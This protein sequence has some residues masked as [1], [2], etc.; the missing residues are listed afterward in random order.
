[1]HAT[2]PRVLTALLLALAALPTDA[3]AQRVP[4]LLAILSVEIVLVGEP[5]PGPASTGIVLSTSDG[6]TT[7]KLDSAAMF[8][9][10]LASDGR[11][12]PCPGVT[13]DG[14][15]GEILV[16]GRVPDPRSFTPEFTVSADGAPA[17]T[18]PTFSGDCRAGGGIDLLPGSENTCRVTFARYETGKDGP[19]AVVVV[20]KHWDPTRPPGTLPDGT[21][22]LYAESDGSESGRIALSDLHTDPL[23]VA[24]V[25]ADARFGP[26]PSLVETIDAAGWLGI[27]GGQCEGD[28][29]D[30]VVIAGRAL[31]CE[32]ANVALE[33]TV[34]NPNRVLRIEAATL[35]TQPGSPETASF[36][37]TMTDGQSVDLHAKQMFGPNL[38]ADGRQ[39]PCSGLTSV[40]CVGDVGLTDITA[41]PTKYETG[42]AVDVTSKP[43]GTIPTFAGECAPDDID[44]GRRAICRVTFV[45]PDESPVDA[46][47]VVSLN[48]EWDNSRP[49]GPLPSGHVALNIGNLGEVA[50]VPLSLLNDDREYELGVFVETFAGFAVVEQFDAPGWFGFVQ[51]P[52]TGAGINDRLRPGTRTRCTV[53][54]VVPE[55]A[56]KEANALMRIETTVIGAPLATVP[57]VTFK[58][59][60]ANGVMASLETHQMLLSDPP[61]GAP[62]PCP[63]LGA[64]VCIG[65]VALKGVT[66]DHGTFGSFSIGMDQIPGRIATFSGDCRPNGRF[67]LA[68]GQ[69]LT[70]RITFVHFDAGPADANAAIRLTKRWD[71][72]RPGSLPQAVLTLSDGSGSQKFA[73]VSTKEL[74]DDGEFILGVALQQASH[75]QLSETTETT[76]WLPVVIR[77]DCNRASDPLAQLTAGR[78]MECEVLNVAVEATPRVTA[79]LGSASVVEGQSA[80]RLVTIPV[81]LSA[82]PL[83]PVQLTYATSNGTATA[84]GDYT[85]KSGTLTI[86]AG[87][88]S[89]SIT[90]SVIGDVLGEPNETFSVVL[91]SAAGAVIADATGVITIVNDDDTTPPTIATKGDIIVETRSVPIA[92]PYVNPKAT[93]LIDGEVAVS[94]Q[95]RSGSS[96][97]YGSTVVRCTSVD[98]NGNQALSTFNIVVR[99]PTTTGAVTNPGNG[100]ALTQVSPG[101]R[102]RVSAGG[103]APGSSLNLSWMAPDDV[104]IAI[105]TAKVGAD[106]R[107]DISVKVPQSAPLGA[108]QM[109]AVGVD[110]AG[111]EF[112]RGW[113]L[114]IVE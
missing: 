95:A 27:V 35:G 14:C 80:T 62:E 89:A 93:D 31:L 114:Q 101:R 13:R 63:G 39:E 54:N 110:A 57:A 105:E 107:F 81:A 52:C 44:F 26:A 34:E 70:C 15:V 92:V 75:V 4:G 82:S 77:G 65:D 104:T 60:D 24:G 9:T 18:V 53:R 21:L 78:L 22:T 43:A 64:A 46:S 97:T 29:K 69:F 51:P 72:S 50:R 88:A 91:T 8:S 1:M 36:R 113:V 12:Q 59:A 48:V 100:T 30:D 66:L 71:T 87:Q 47:A 85:A 56:V 40:G 20:T 42:F 7:V 79:S 106:G 96:F 112:V 6:M 102:V 3:A 84:P 37:V 19:T 2:T 23:W 45:Y 28:S 67:D 11:Q 33:A 108:G 49:A 109:T 90:I 76:G 32:V 55:V 83:L 94:C 38:L 98:R 10:V 61:S 41:L 73:D 111:A 5:L 17:G 103:F 58:I 86:A 16:T 25:A 99:T 74:G 68:P